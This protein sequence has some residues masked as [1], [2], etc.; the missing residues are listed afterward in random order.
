MQNWTGIAYKIPRI[1]LE[2]CKDGKSSIVS[3]YL[4]FGYC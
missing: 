3:Q 4:F 2:E 1:K